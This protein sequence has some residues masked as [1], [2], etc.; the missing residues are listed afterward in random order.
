V[1]ALEK[2]FDENLGVGS[3]LSVPRHRAL[4]T[5]DKL[6]PQLRSL[7]H[8]YGLPI[9]TT[10][11]KHGVTNPAKI[12]ELVRDIWAG[13]RQTQQNGSAHETLDWLLMQAGAN[14]SAKKLRRFLADNNLVICS[15]EP[16]R[17]ML[18]ASM[19]EVSGHNFRCTREEKHRLRLR[20]ALRSAMQESIK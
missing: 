10:C 4:E 7:V 12:R 8:E 18:N 3:A 17:P 6:P 2:V 20:A 5:T 19:A 15:A 14:I 16:T 11:V 13:A 1:N 9:I